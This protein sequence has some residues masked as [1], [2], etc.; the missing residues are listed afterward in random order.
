MIFLIVLVGIPGFAGTSA[1]IFDGSGGEILI[2]TSTPGI[3]VDNFQVIGG[4]E[5]SAKQ[6]VSSYSPSIIVREGGFSG[7]GSMTVIT[8]ATAPEVEFGAYLQASS[9]GYLGQT[10]DTSS[11]VMFDLSVWGEGEGDLQIFSE[12]PGRVDFNFGL[13]FDISTM[14][15]IAH[16]NPFSISWITSFDQQVQTSGTAEAE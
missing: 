5:F 15:V 9:S 6:Q 3:S 2:V 7:G 13:L 1:V 10:V 4:G 14:S 11:S 12:A 16:S 8:D